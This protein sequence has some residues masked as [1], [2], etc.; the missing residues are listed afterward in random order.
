M[1]IEHGRGTHMYD[2]LFS[3]EEYVC[4]KEPNGFLASAATMMQRGPTLSLAEGEG[5]NAVYLASLG[6][7]VLAVDASAVD[8]AKAARLASE[9]GV[10]IR[11][12][13]SDLADLEMGE[14]QFENIVSV[15]CHVPPRLR[16][17]LHANVV[18]AL[19]PGGVFLLEAF[20]PEQ[21]R[22]SSGGPTQLE[23]LV[24]REQVIGELTGLEMIRVGEVIRK[25]CEGEYHIGCSAVLDIIA[26]KPY[27]HR[28][29]GVPN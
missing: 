20:R 22:F 1:M 3:E 12:Q 16:R 2:E 11:T 17:R 9:C 28:P 25:L 13:H 23:L 14:E 24:T 8:L 18:R 26:R 15:F 21:L 4:G 19:R 5:S 6:F 29:R 10:S 7:D 27:V